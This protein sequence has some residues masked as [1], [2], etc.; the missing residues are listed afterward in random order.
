MS[1]KQ[2]IKYNLHVLFIGLKYASLSF[3]LVADKVPRFLVS[4]EGHAGNI[5]LSRDMKIAVCAT[6][7][8]GGN[9]LA[10]IFHLNGKYKTDT[11][12]K[13]RKTMHRYT[14]LGNLFLRKL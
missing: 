11:F 8:C 4:L 12:S 5:T 14:M 3:H 7:K 9:C 6:C 1:F 13:K 2:F 10:D